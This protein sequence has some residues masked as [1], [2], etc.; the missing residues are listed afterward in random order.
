[1][2]RTLHCWCGG[3]SDPHLDMCADPVIKARG[4]STPPR[5]KALP[6]HGVPDVHAVDEE[7]V[8]YGRPHV[9]REWDDES[10]DDVKQC[11]ISVDWMIAM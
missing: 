4:P 7:R 9:P 3:G 5:G 2:V 8:E 6:Q 10:A 1:M 11:K